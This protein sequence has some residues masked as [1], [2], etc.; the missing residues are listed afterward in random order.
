MAPNIQSTSDP[1]RRPLYYDAEGKPVYEDASNNAAQTQ[2]AAMNQDD[3]THSRPI[4]DPNSGDRPEV[5]PAAKAAQ[6]NVLGPEQ[7]SPSSHITSAPQ[8]L[9][10]QSFDPQMRSQY[11]N[12]PGTVHSTREIEPEKREISKELQKRHE[13]S[14]KRYPRLNLSEG[15]VVILS[16]RRHPIGL[17]LPLLGGG[18]AILALI[19]ALIVYP[20]D[21]AGSALPSY[22]VFVLLVTL[23]MVLIGIGTYLAIWVYQKN[24]FFMTNESVIQEIQHSIFSKREQTVSLG[25]IEDASFRKSGILQTMLDYG[26]IRLSTE[27][28]ETTYRFAYVENPREQVA[29]LNN[30]VEAFKNGRPVELHDDEN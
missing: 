30:G 8:S 14:K 15:E 20:M 12:E 9:E 29:I 28:E 10:G 3:V 26:T 21:T 2:P 7:T 23:V 13:E 5:P 19:V 24:Q 25:S 4:L 18:S 1:S 16:I 11:A 6:A 27:G 17:F 22:G